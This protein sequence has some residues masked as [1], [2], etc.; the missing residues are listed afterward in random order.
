M[1]NN[2]II[3]LTATMFF[4]ACEK[5]DGNG[6]DPS[7]QL[8]FESLIADRYT[9]V[10]GES[11]RIIATATGYNLSYHWSATAG[12]ILGSGAEVI[13]APSPCHAG[14]NEIT[15]EVKDGNNNSQLKSVKI[16]VE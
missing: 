5:D 9:L 15:C 4:I 16:V 7:Q 1:K 12:D 3:M 11:T 8:V 2:L 14:E 10:A 13:Y 6:G